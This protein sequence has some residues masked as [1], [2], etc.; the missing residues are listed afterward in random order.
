VA[1]TDA[2]GLVISPGPCGPSE[3]GICVEVIQAL[4]GR[5][6]CWACASGTRPSASAYG[7][8]GPAGGAGARQGVRDR[9][10][11]PGNLRRAPARF[12]AARYHSLA[13]EEASLPSVLE[14]S[15]RPADG[16]PMAIRTA[17]IRL[18][19]V[20]FHPE[21]ILTRAGAQLIANF[22]RRAADLGQRPL[23]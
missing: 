21:S 20:Q 4:G 2:A 7:C 23:S 8:R 16:L 11:R 17:P 22:V 1:A 5:L 12:E 15:A 6:R 13:I 18:D 14:V 3:A 19:G 10:R 9:A